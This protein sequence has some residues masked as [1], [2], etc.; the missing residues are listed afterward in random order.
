MLKEKLNITS[1][2]LREETQYVEVTKKD[3]ETVDFKLPKN[4]SLLVGNSAS[5][6]CNHVDVFEALAKKDLKGDVV[7]PLS[8]AGTEYY[9]ERVV[10]AGKRIFGKKFKP[11][12]TMMRM[13]DYER[14]IGNC[15]YAFFAEKRQHAGANI[16]MC[17]NSGVAVFLFDENKLSKRYQNM[18]IVLGRMEE[19]LNGKEIEETAPSHMNRIENVIRMRK[20]VA[21]EK[22]D[23]V[24]RKAFEFALF[25]KTYGVSDQ[26]A[27]ETSDN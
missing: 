21:E 23:E 26:A 4:G 13:E 1:V 11:I 17:L 9:K 24:Y 27:M 14:I 6:A 3:V 7:C 16:R 5:A 20:G 19:L 15:E 10:E 18:G 22:I 12:L 25:G 8:Y 2:N